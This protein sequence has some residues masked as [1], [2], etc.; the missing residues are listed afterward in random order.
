MNHTSGPIIKVAVWKMM[1]NHKTFKNRYCIHSD[2]QNGLVRFTGWSF[3]PPKNIG[4][5]LVQKER[6]VQKY[7]QSIFL[8]HILM[9]ICLKFFHSLFFR[10]KYDYNTRFS[11]FYFKIKK[12]K[13][14]KNYPLDIFWLY[15]KYL[16]ICQMRHKVNDR[17]TPQVGAMLHFAHVTVR[18]AHFLVPSNWIC[19]INNEIRYKWT[20]DPIKI[21]HKHHR[22]LLIISITWNSCIEIVAFNFERKYCVD[23]ELHIVEVIK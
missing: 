16:N 11:E 1:R 7:T 14:F 6:L 20:S 3:L 13:L 18:M 15:F 22:N 19:D 5:C 8:V 23:I 12:K 9:K 4:L 21:Q 2:I 17:M 10:R